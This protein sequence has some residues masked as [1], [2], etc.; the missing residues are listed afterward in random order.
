MKS[1]ILYS[2]R[3]LVDLDSPSDYIAIP[4]AGGGEIF[5]RAESRD[6]NIDDALFDATP[7]TGEVV[8]NSVSLDAEAEADASHLFET[9]V[10]PVSKT[11]SKSSIVDRLEDETHTEV[12]TSLN[13]SYP[14]PHQIVEFIKFLDSATGTGPVIGEVNLVQ[15][16]VYVTVNGAAFNLDGERERN[17]LVELAELWWETRGFIPPAFDFVVRDGRVELGVAIFQLHPELFQRD[18]KALQPMIAAYPGMANPNVTRDGTE[19]KIGQVWRDLDKRM[20]G[21]T[22]EIRA[23]SDG[24]AF[25]GPSLKT[26]IRIS[27]MHKHSSGFELVSK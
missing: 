13:A 26:K 5:V 8:L 7:R 11:P 10:P 15:S 23:V 17:A 21:R 12:V 24:Y 27:R 16:R 9:V 3:V 1:A 14:S 4:V 25:A 6:M 20:R 19:V 2:K 18:W 22:I